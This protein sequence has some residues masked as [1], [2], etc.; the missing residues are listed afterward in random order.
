MKKYWQSAIAISFLG[1]YLVFFSLVNFSAAATTNPAAAKPTY[2]LIKDPQNAGITIKP[3]EV[4]PNGT[5]AFERGF[6]FYSNNPEEI[7]KES[8]ADN[9][10]WLNRAEVSGQ[11]QVYVWHTNGS[12]ETITSVLYIQNNNKKEDITI[13]INKYGLTN[14]KNSTDIPAWDTYF[15]QKQERIIQTLKPGQFIELLPQNVAPD[16]NFGIIAEVNITDK[17]GNPATALMDDRVYYKESLKNRAYR[18]AKLDNSRNRCRGIGDAYQSNITF[19]TVTMSEDTYTA[20]SIG[21]LDDSLKGKDLVNITDLDTKKDTL[22]EGSYGEIITITIPV[23]NDYKAYQNFGI[24]IGSIGGHSFPFV[25]MEKTSIIDTY[26]KPFKAY[27]MVQTGHMP[28]DTTQT[29]TFS[30]VIPALSSTPLVIGVHP[31]D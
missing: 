10:Y 9:G 13:T 18:Y 28:L 31:I 14:C 17:A 19:D 24:F 21:A 12:N 1:I 26:V 11:G 15:N 25:K 2:S 27:D 7:K 29:V 5:A 4:K 8:W 16:C 30:L 3:S 22:L 23:K 20:F 6:F